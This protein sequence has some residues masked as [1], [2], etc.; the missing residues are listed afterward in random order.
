MFE[1]I[2]EVKY[3]IRNLSFVTILSPVRA[4][5]V[6]GQGY[7]VSLT[8]YRYRGYDNCGKNQ[9]SPVHVSGEHPT[10]LAC[11]QELRKRLNDPSRHDKYAEVFAKQA[12]ADAASAA[13]DMFKH[14]LTVS[15]PHSRSLS[16]YAH[17]FAGDSGRKST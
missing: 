11:F 10:E 16:T 15:H 2:E 3:D 13:T 5:K 1:Q 14:L 7:G 4:V 8:C 9:E 17:C 12:S 6:K